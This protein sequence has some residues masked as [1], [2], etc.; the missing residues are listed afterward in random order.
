MFD[1]GVYY[2]EETDEAYLF[3]GGGVDNRDKSNP[4]TGRVVKLGKDMISLDGTPQTME[5]P[6][7]FEDSSIIKIGDT[8]YYSFCA[9]WNVPG[10]TS[11]NGQ[12]FGNAD[13]CYLTSKNP[14]GP[15]TKSQFGG[16]AFANTFSQGLD[17]GGNNHHS[18]VEFKGK[19]YVLYHTRQLDIRK[20]N[21]A[22]KSDLNYRSPSINEATFS[23]G[24]I[25]CK[26][27][28]AGVSQL[29][30]LDAYKTVQAETMS[31]Q[32]TGISVSGVGDT[33]VSMKKGDWIKVSGVNLKNGVDSITV[34]GAAKS[35]GAIKFCVGSPTGDVIGYA[36]LGSSSAETTVSAV[37]SPTGTKDIYIVA[38]ND[39]IEL[40]YWYFS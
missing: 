25:T 12:S 3:F 10:G 1:P 11:Y 32:S 8:W 24:K 35:G 2:D 40:D 19:Y 36:E 5:T 34:K 39:N 17:N 28:H 33:T 31:N 38:S 18:I 29:E 21:K 20:L 13:I 6:Y 16:M 15:W 14:L 27:S 7:L 30:S 37:S 26:G 22:D 23:N 4:K 9:N